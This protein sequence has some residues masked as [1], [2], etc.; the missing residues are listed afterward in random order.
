MSISCQK[1]KEVAMKK[2]IIFVLILLIPPQVI[3]AKWNTPYHSINE[4]NLESVAMGLHGST[5]EKTMVRMVTYMGKN[6]S[7]SYDRDQFKMNDYWQS[8]EEMFRR[9][10]GDCEDSAILMTDILRRNGI[11]SEVWYIASDQYELA[12][13]I[14]VTQYKDGW[15][16]LDNSYKVHPFQTKKETVMAYWRGQGGTSLY[17][18]LNNLMDKPNTSEMVPAMPVKIVGTTSNRIKIEAHLTECQGN[19]V[20]FLIP[21]DKEKYASLVHKEAIGV[22]A[23]VN[24]RVLKGV[25]FSYSEHGWYSPS[26]EYNDK[27][28]SLHLLFSHI[29]ASFYTGDY[30][31][32]DIDVNPIWAKQL[33]VYVNMRNFGQVWDY[34]MVLTPIKYVEGQVELNDK[35]LDYGFYLKLFDESDTGTFLRLGITDKKTCT[36][37]LFSPKKEISISFG[38]P[39]TVSMA[40]RW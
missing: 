25:G 27:R 23:K 3:L 21:A 19:E 29:G 6:Y 20:E 12:H 13:A 2:L 33:K 8:P 24:S 18:L 38:R 14:L 28:S 11:D 1:I 10:K 5:N 30:Q 16:Y 36:V 37:N 15:A 31:G 34:K 40:Y 35:N 26:R 39:M 9:K 32:V 7:Y 4:N 22:L 17:G